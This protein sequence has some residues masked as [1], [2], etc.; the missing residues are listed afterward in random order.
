VDE[1]KSLAAKGQKGA[2]I[3]LVTD[4]IDGNSA[5]QTEAVQAALALDVRLW[6]VAIECEISDDSP[7]RSKA[8]SYTRL[9]RGDLTDEKSVIPLAGAM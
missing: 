7:L 1:V 2:D 6:T 4:G 5:A 3:I 8:A 9:G